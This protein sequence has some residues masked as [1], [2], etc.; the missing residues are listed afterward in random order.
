MHQE[1]TCS[2]LIYFIKRQ[3]TE[4]VHDTITILKSQQ[5]LFKYFFNG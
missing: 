5:N 3:V 2:D 1:Y 4:G